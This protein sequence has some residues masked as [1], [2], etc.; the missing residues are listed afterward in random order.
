MS[1]NILRRPLE[2]PLEFLRRRRVAARLLIV[3]AQADPDIY[4]VRQL[5]AE[6]LQ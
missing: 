1:L 3:Q 4:H 5:L 2:H 6:F